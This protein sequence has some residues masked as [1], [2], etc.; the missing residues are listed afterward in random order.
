MFSTDSL[1]VDTRIT[2][3]TSHA[4]HG[5]ICHSFALTGTSYRGIDW[6]MPIFD[7][8]SVAYNRLARG[9]G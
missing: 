1:P 8:T 5:L 4:V 9:G 7:G 6:A 2:S 3:P